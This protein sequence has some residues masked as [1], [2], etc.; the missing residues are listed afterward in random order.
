[1]CGLLASSIFT[2]VILTGNASSSPSFLL[3]LPP[4]LLNLNPNDDQDAEEDEE[5]GGRE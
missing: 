4:S 3:S 2:P 1:V 5:E